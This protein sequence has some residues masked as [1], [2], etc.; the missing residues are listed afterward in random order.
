MLTMS[1]SFPRRSC[2]RVRGLR[3]LRPCLSRA[4]SSRRHAP[5]GID[6]VVDRCVRDVQVRFFGMHTF[7]LGGHLLR[8]EARLQVLTY[9]GPQWSVRMQ[10]ALTARLAPQP[11]R[12]P[13]RA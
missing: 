12:P 10:L 8:R 1:T 11:C 3:V 9:L 6:G 5:R 4:T 13:A 7:E 2:P